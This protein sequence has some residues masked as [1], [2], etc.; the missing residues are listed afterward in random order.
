[1]CLTP[2]NSAITAQT[3]AI[4]ETIIDPLTVRRASSTA[5]RAFLKVTTV[6]LYI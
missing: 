4:T 5:A 6:A 2:R 1:L 3:S